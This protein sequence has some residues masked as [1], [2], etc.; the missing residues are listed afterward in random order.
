MP[1]HFPLSE[2]NKHTRYTHRNAESL[3]CQLQI[4]MKILSQI[5]IQ[6]QMEM[7]LEMEMQM[8]TP[9]PS[10][11]LQSHDNKLS[12]IFFA[13]EADEQQLQRLWVL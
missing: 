2:T 9:A 10:E 13:G 5:Q 6:L 11:N 12:L 8:S 3:L 7:L 4:R 1:S